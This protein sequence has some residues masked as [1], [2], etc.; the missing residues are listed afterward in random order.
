MCGSAVD[1]NLGCCVLLSDSG[2]DCCCCA[3]VD[4]IS[5]AFTALSLAALSMCGWLD[6]VLSEE[7]VGGASMEAVME[8]EE[9]EAGA[10]VAALLVSP[11]PLM[12]CGDAVGSRWCG[13][14]ELATLLTAAGITT[15]GVTL[16]GSDGLLS[17]AGEE[18]EE[19][20]DTT[21][22]EEVVRCWRGVGEVDGIPD[23]EKVEGVGE[24]E[25]A[26]SEVG[27][28][29][30]VVGVGEGA[31]VG[32]EVGASNSRDEQWLGGARR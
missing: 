30:G 1:G 18:A 20:T 23:M 19:A 13:G 8:E 12:V 7:E 31:A 24:G 27:A 32:E 4:R 26:V 3:A 22:E 25:R 5:A 21:D 10:D 28:S 15:C 17:R 29:M 14:G 16:S 2:D 9:A 11:P 6:S